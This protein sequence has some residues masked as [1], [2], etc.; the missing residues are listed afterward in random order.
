MNKDYV[1]GV[2]AGL[3]PKESVRLRTIDDIGGVY[4]AAGGSGGTGEFTGVDLTDAGNWD[5][6]VSIMVGLLFGTIITLL[7]IPSFYS[8]LFKVNYKSYEFNEKLLEN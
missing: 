8:I 4:N 6:A 7:L 5:L 1:D 2:A 3:D